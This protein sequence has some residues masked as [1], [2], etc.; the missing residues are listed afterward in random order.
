MLE[1]IQNAQR[2]RARLRYPPN[3]V[4]D[5]GI[6]LH[7]MPRGFFLVGEQP[8]P[9]EP[10]EIIEEIIL[11]DPPRP[12]VNRKHIMAKVAA[13]YGLSVLDLKGPFRTKAVCLPRHVAFYLLKEVLGL[14]L[15]ETGRVMNRDHTT[16][17]HGIRQIKRLIL[18][19]GE[20][21]SDIAHLEAQ[22][23]VE[24]EGVA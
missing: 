11:I 10:P 23:I 2:I 18:I 14:S 19:D 7:R 15:P 24:M 21:A 1:A 22:L 4:P 8:A 16:V 12:V 17:L 9:I 5:H 13:F 3:A 20:L 6:D